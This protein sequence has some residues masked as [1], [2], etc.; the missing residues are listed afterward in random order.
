[1]AG[2]EGPGKEYSEMEKFRQG[3]MPHIGVKGMM[4]MMTMIL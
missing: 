3:P 2:S 4:M 1:M